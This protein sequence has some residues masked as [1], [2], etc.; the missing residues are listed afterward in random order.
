VQVVN[1]LIAA[2]VARD[3][4]RVAAQFTDDAVFRAGPIGKLSPARKPQDFFKGLVDGASSIE[5]KIV[6]TFPI[7][8]IVVHDRHDRILSPTR[9]IVGRWA[10]IF[11]LTNGKITEFTDYTLDNLDW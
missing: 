10:G 5:M 9:T 8:P 6:S 3:A 7:G 4:A 2:F 1:D 11:A